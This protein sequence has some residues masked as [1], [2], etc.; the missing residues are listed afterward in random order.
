M[1]IIPY[2][3]L[4]DKHRLFPLFYH[5]GHTPLDYRTFERRSQLDFRFRDGPKGFCAIEDDTPVGFGGVMHIPTRTLCGEEVVGGVWA[6]STDPNYMRRGIGR[7]IMEAIHAYFRQQG[8]PF[9]FL[10][11]YRSWGAYEM[12]RKLGY[13]EVPSVIKAPT[14]YKFLPAQDAVAGDPKIESPTQDS[15]A[16]LFEEFTADST[17]FVVRPPDFF[18]LMVERG[19][20]DTALSVG[21]EDGYAL[22][23]EF[24]GRIF[25]R[26]IAARNRTVQTTL[27][28]A[29]EAKGKDVIIDPVVTTPGLMDGYVSNGYH[30]YNG[31][32]GTVMVKPLADASFEEAYGD[33]F[34]MS[35]LEWF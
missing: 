10:T 2:A 7:A 11:T 24:N 32:H 21:T 9:A 17:G 25:I 3:Q 27:L 19:G 16:R 8:F 14:A 26:E 34:Y 30:T 18:S 22:V 28:E 20:F 6:V 35:S 33:R 4:K 1:D 23:R 13:I 31:R 29:L 15:V 5:A 12:Y